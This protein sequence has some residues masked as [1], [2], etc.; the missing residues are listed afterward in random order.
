MNEK[1]ELFH[2]INLKV[3]TALLTLGFEKVTISK[4]V[5]ADGK[6]SVVFWFNAANADGLR[7]DTV[8]DGMT[9]GGDALAEKDPENPINYMRVFAHNRDELVADIHKTPRMVEVAKDGRR[10][11]IA[12]TAS[13]ETKRKIAEML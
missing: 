11:L 8:L 13:E 2:T 9:R 5:R 1:Q 7:A 4:I 12:E 3:A 10:V 6:E